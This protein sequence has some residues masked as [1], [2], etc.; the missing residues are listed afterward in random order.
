MAPIRS[1]PLL[2]PRTTELQARAAV[3]VGE[4]TRYNVLETIYRRNAQASTNGAR[5]LAASNLTTG[6]AVSFS[7]YVRK[8]RS[9]VF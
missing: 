7:P 2:P 5:P 6:A 8:K 9:R 3:A 4:K 1:V